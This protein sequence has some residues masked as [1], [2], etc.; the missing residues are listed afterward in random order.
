[1]YCRRNNFEC[2]RQTDLNNGTYT[3]LIPASIHSTWELGWYDVQVAVSKQYYNGT[4][5]LFTNSFFL[6]TKPQFKTNSSNYLLSKVEHVGGWGEI[7]TFEIGIGDD[8]WNK[9][10]VSLYINLTGNWQLVNSTIISASPTPQLVE[11]TGH[12]FD[13]G[14]IGVKDVMFVA[15][16]EF[17]Y[18]TNSTTTM[19]IEKDDTTIS[20][21]SPYSFTIRREGN[22]NATLQVIVY[23]AD[24]NNIP[25]VANVSYYVTSDGSNYLF[26]GRN[27]S[28][29]SGNAIFVFNPDCNYRVG[30]QYWEAGTES[31]ACYKDNIQSVAGSKNYN[32]RAIKAIFEL[33][34]LSAGY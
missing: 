14:K 11:F 26:A 32:N 12:T 30:L 33:S 23:D 9:V 15:T 20:F 3:C 7:W 2:L 29:S 18:S 25:I 8:D 10:N 4:T 6:A 21:V 17:N 5:Q 16:D 27:Q 1:L 31:N 13:C 19:T 24:R 34:K 22:D 28:D